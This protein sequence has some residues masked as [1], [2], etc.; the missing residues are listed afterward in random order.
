MKARLYVQGCSQQPGIDYYDQTHCATM[1]GTSL[2]LLSALAG[3]HGLLMRRWDFV[4]AYLEG[5]LEEGEVV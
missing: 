4:S 2:R 5:K 3:K 1:H